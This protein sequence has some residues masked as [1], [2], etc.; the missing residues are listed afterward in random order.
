MT[1]SSMLNRSNFLGTKFT[2][3][4]AHPP[5]DEAMISKGRS[6]RV[7]GS[8]QMSPRVPAGNY[9]VSHISYGLNV[10]GSRYG[11][12]CNITSILPILGSCFFLRRLWSRPSCD[13]LSYFHELEFE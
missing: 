7:I 2:V 4:D 10:M 13:S 1:Y 6:A 8:T 5:C 12:P 11:K 9:P 3:Y